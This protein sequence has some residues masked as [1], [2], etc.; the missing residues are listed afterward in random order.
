MIFGTFH[1]NLRGTTKKIMLLFPTAS[2]LPGLGGLLVG[3]F[4]VTGIF[5]GCELLMGRW[6][7]AQQKPVVGI[8]KHTF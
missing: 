7:I 4:F 6:N 1:K 5:A 2:K 8:S 3:T